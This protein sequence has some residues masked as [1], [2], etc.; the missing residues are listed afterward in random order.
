VTDTTVS[1]LR[2][3]VGASRNGAPITAGILVREKIM[4]VFM[5]SLIFATVLGF[6]LV[7]VFGRMVG[8]S[9]FETLEIQVKLALLLM[10]RIGCLGSW[11]TMSWNW[12]VFPF[13]YNFGGTFPRF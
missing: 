8:V 2:V 5:E 10:L 4:R 11:M 1:P 12:H 7:F 6:G 9:E 3:G 13:L